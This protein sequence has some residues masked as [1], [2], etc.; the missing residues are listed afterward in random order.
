MPKLCVRDDRRRK[1]V[2]KLRK[3]EVY[4]AQGNDK[5]MHLVEDCQAELDLGETAEVIV[6]TAP[7]EGY[8]R[9]TLTLIATPLGHE[10]Y[11]LC[12]SKEAVR[13]LRAGDIF[14][15]TQYPATLSELSKG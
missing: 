12:N 13:P 5:L 4:K 7:Q 6:H 8:G 3:N 11:V 1:P 9:C 10:S 15:V 14:H 2:T